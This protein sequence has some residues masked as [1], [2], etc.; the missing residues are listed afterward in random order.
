MVGVVVVAAHARA[1]AQG[2]SQVA[3]V[4]VATAASVELQVVSA[5]AAASVG[6]QSVVGGLRSVL[7]VSTSLV[8]WVLMLLRFF[9]PL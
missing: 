3:P 6:P 4:V 8:P 5:V 9:A 1:H 2:P 7:V